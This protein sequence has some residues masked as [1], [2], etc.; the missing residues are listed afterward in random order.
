MGVSP[1]CPILLLAF[2][3]S[4]S[5]IEFASLT[6]KAFPVEKFSKVRAGPSDEEGFLWL[7]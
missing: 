5:G 6:E 3:G 1:S 4:R 7:H 2:Q